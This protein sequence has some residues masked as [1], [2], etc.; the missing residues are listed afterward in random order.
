ML[1]GWLLRFAGGYSKR[2]N[3]VNPTFPG[4]R[5]PA[6]KIV[7]CENHY[8][9]HGLPTIFRLPSIASEPTLDGLLAA[10]GYGRLDKTSVRVASLTAVSAA[11][12]G[13]I[14][15]AAAPSVEWLETQCRWHGLDRERLARHQAILA[16]IP[17]PA[18]FV[19]LRE[20]GTI[21]ALGVVVLQGE[22]A[23]LNDIATD[24]ARR[25]RGFG[26]GLT[27]ALMAWAR[28]GGAGMAYLQVVKTNR[29]AL[30]LYGRLGFTQ[31]LYRYHYRVRSP[32]A[33]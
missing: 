12:D 15:I 11:E 1:D 26:R 4:R 23:C 7:V 30:A 31:E 29:P 16:A 3:S 22:Y 14:E 20:E 21:A 33:D 17:H 27:L 10:R 13:A 32:R 19:A 24:P 25:R 9:R 18:A 28:R 6:E 5:A 8:A 2:A